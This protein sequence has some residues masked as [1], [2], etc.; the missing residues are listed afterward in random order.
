MNQNLKVN[1]LA[2]MIRTIRNY[3]EITIDNLAQI[4]DVP[5]PTV[6]RLM[7]QLE[8]KGVV[9]RCSKAESNMGR[10]AGIY[11]VNSQYKFILGVNLDKFYVRAFI[12][13]LSCQIHVQWQCT[14]DSSFS[15]ERILAAIDKG[16]EAVVGSVLYPDG[17]GSKIA[18]LSLGVTA[19]I[20]SDGESIRAFSQH[21]CMNGFNIVRY[22]REKYCMRVV[23]A[24]ASTL[25][26]IAYM[27]ELNKKGID[28]YVYAYIG[29]GIGA[30]V[31]VGGKLYHGH[32]GGAGEFARAPL[33][34]QD[35]SLEEVYSLLNLYEQI[36]NYCQTSNDV[37]LRNQLD[38]LNQLDVEHNQRM[39]LAAD[40]CL[41]NGREQ[42]RSQIESY[43]REWGRLCCMMVCFYDPQMIVIGGEIST[44]TPN[45]YECIKKAFLEANE[46]QVE[47]MAAR[48]VTSWDE[49]ISMNAVDYVIEDIVLDFLP[50]EKRA[51]KKA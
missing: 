31:V 3:G 6:Y 45:V 33:F 30:G 10:K 42:I 47:I 12:A 25:Q 37:E 32:H 48:A 35:K 46:S 13:D 28:D 20:A 27:D 2:K 36:Q 9:Q 44:K 17:D 23:L 4:V 50:E 38:F 1:N 26:T 22:M 21:E 5:K 19:A 18:A 16:I 34:G 41:A 51:L 29:T 15:K 7:N 24:K 49:L 40:Y 8:L 14:I 11:T 43:C 39:V